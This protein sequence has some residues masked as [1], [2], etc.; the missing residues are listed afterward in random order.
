[1]LICAVRERDRHHYPAFASAASPGQPPI[2]L[3]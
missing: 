1:M 3:L 2:V